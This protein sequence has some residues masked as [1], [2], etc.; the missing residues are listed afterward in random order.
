MV[1]G[2][3]LVFIIRFH[4]CVPVAE[5]YPGFCVSDSERSEFCVSDLFVAVV[6][7]DGMCRFALRFLGI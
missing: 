1:R 4:E 2:F 7:I 6:D 3:L 5:K